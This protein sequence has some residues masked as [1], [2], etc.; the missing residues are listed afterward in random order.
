M[1]L[2]GCDSSENAGSTV[3]ELDWVLLEYV[4]MVKDTV[5]YLLILLEDP[6]KQL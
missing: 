3:G 6:T 4:S 5:E 2:E 1:G